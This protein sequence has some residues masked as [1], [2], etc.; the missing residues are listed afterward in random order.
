M[1]RLCKIVNT[2]ENFKDKIKNIK[3]ETLLIFGK[4]DKAT[5]VWMGKKWNRYIAK[6]RLIIYKNAGHFCYIDDPIRFT[7]DVLDFFGTSQM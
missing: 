6:S 4:N 2:T 3:N 7:E 5:P 1:C